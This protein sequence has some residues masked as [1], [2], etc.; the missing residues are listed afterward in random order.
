MTDQNN[1]NDK[2]LRD[3]LKRRLLEQD[4]EDDL[5][6]QK[7]LDMEAKLAFSEEAPLLPSLQKENDFLNRL[8]GTRSRSGLLRW[9]LPVGALLLIGSV[10]VLLLNLPTPPIEPQKEMLASTMPLNDQLPEQRTDVVVLSDSAYAETRTVQLKRVE[11]DTLQKDTVQVEKQE[12]Y[13]AEN[14]GINVEY[15]PRK[16]DP[17]FVDAANNIPTLT[18]KE[19]RVTQAYKTQMIKQILKKDKNW[20]YVP[21]STDT[22]YGDV[23]SMS[24]FYMA[25]TEVTNNQYRTFLND[26]IIQGKLEEFVKAVPDTSKWISN[27]RALWYRFQPDSAKWDGSPAAFFEPMRKNYYWHP[28]YDAYPVVCVSREGAKMYCDWLTNAVNEKIKKDYP[29]NKWESMFINDLRIPQDLEWMMAARAGHGSIDYPW[30]FGKLPKGVQNSHGC[31]LANFC[32]R[33][34]KE[35]IACP[36]K[37]FPDAYTSAG[38][39]SRDYFFVC[40]V[41][42]YNPNDY[43]VFCMAGNV[44]EMVIVGKTGKA[45]TKGGSWDSDAEHIKIN[46]EDQ[47]A[48]VTEGSMYVGFRPVFTSKPKK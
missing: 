42:S 40:P 41:G 36:N 37:K 8:K 4:A 26:L 31:Y 2:H 17:K 47:Y 22:F 45:G 34:Y 20:C 24:A 16:H 1:L 3:L 29:E 48:G 15:K 13:K 27:G 43:G 7:L 30:A 23:V 32:I 9:I 6:T 10:T 38:S 12:T 39:I 14:A 25:A 46:S 19:I 21:M 11:V 5:L 35:E 28:A 44:A 33:N 18:E